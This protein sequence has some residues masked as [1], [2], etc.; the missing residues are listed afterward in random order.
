MALIKLRENYSNHKQYFDG[1]DIKNFS[2]YSEQDEKIGTVDDLLVDDTQGSFRYLIVDLGFWIFGKKVL[3]PVG[4]TRLDQSDKRVYAVGM[5]KDQAENL[6]EFKESMTV[7]Y[8]Y[9]EQV[10]GVYRG[11]DIGTAS[12]AYGTATPQT[13]TS[14]QYDRNSYRY[15][16]DRDLY[17]MNDRGHQTLKLYEERLIADKHQQKVG[18]V[19][20]GKHVETEK[21]K[22]SVPLNK[23][24]VVIERSDANVGQAV[25]GNQADFREGEVARME[26]HEEVPDIRKEAYVREEVK[27][28]KEVEQD[29]VDAQETLRREKLDLDTSGRKIEDRR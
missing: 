26:V 12:A 10:R 24:K 16:Y 29:T 14:G 5:T 18:E 13:A 4:R 6:P 7:D 27:L 2:V 1:E 11:S 17:D 3:L 19:K 23:E 28:R 22:A 8:D 9:E 21:A 25:P 20:V 15:D